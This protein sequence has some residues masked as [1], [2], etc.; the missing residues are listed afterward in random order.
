VLVALAPSNADGDAWWLVD[1]VARQVLAG[2]GT[3]DKDAPW[4]IIAPAATWEQMIRGEVNIGTAFRR[5]GM[6]YHDKGDG[7]PGSVVAENRV[8]MIGDLLGITSWRPGPA[9]AFG[10]LLTADGA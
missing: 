5:H 3:C 1:L 6:R 8:G 4:T 7:P 10:V 2:S 9:G